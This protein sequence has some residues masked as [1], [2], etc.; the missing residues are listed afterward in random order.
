MQYRAKRCVSGTWCF[1]AANSTCNRTFR[2]TGNKA[3]WNPARLHITKPGKALRRH[4]AGST[5]LNPQRQW[6]RKI[7]VWIR[8]I[9]VEKN[10][11]AKLGLRT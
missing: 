1:A 6:I 9:G 10:Q 3:S 5:R 8:K 7:G 11:L 2:K 4:M